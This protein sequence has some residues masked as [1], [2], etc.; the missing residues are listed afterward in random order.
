MSHPFIKLSYRQVIDASYAGTFEENV[1]HDS[2]AEF[3]IQAQ[4]YNRENTCN[5]WQELLAHNPKAASLHY[6]VG[7]AIGLYVGELNNY[8]P[9]LE[10]MRGR[11]NVPFATYEF[12]ILDSDL[13]NPEA[14]KVA[15]HYL[16]DPLML[17]MQAG[18]HLVLSTTNRPSGGMAAWVETFTLKIQPGLSVV[19]YCASA[20]ATNATT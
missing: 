3:S 11:C 1:F 18:D 14:H 9:K 7:F 13:R 8:I 19:D 10:D 12:E 5:T 17:V 20:V 16:T 6:K 4:V 15:I 2:Y